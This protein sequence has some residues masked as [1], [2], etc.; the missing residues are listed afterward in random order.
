MESPYFKKVKASV[1]DKD[2]DK[3][4]KEKDKQRE[5]ETETMISSTQPQPAISSSSSSSTTQRVCEKLQNGVIHLKGFLSA[6]EQVHL[7]QDI[8]QCAKSYAPTRA[9][10]AKSNFMKII[11]FNP[12][13]QAHIFLLFC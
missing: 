5:K 8:K 2:K 13:K 1:E 10:N 6:E 3:E 12:K 7:W 11:A 4:Q 9:R